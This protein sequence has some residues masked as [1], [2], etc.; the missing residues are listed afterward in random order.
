MDPETYMTLDHD[1]QYEIN[2]LIFSL[3][4]KLK[5]TRANLATAQSFKRSKNK[6]S[7]ICDKLKIIDRDTIDDERSL[8]YQTRKVCQSLLKI[9]KH[10]ENELQVNLVEYFLKYCKKHS[11]FFYETAK[12]IFD[13]EF[14]TNFNKNV[15]KNKKNPERQE[16]LAISRIVT[17]LSHR[18]NRAVNK[19]V[20]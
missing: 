4:L 16:F 10:C 17:G 19:Q 5:R 11:N 12:P 6:L 2:S 1:T 7:K 3:A 13:K 18:Q 8:W 14:C 9:F 20:C 15:L